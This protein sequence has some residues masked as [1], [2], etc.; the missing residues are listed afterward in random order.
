MSL[1]PD[2]TLARELH[3]GLNSFVCNVLQHAQGSNDVAE[4]LTEI[5][6]LAHHVLADTASRQN[7]SNFVYALPA[8][9]LCHILRFLFLEDLTNAS[10]TCRYFRQLALAEPSLWTHIYL[11]GRHGKF[12]RGIFGAEPYGPAHSWPFDDYL[13]VLLTRA[14]SAPVRLIVRDLTNT[15]IIPLAYAIRKHAFHLRAVVI[16][17]AHTQLMKAEDL[18]DFARRYAETSN[19][20]SQIVSYPDIVIA[21][22]LCEPAPLLTELNLSRTSSYGSHLPKQL[23]AACPVLS[24]IDLT[25]FDIP[26]IDRPIHS[27]TKL[28][29]V[30]AAGHDPRGMS[31]AD[32]FRKFP[33]LRDLEM[34][35]V[36]RQFPL[37]DMAETDSLQRLYIVPVDEN[38]QFK[39]VR[40]LAPTRIADITIRFPAFSIVRPFIESAGTIH[41]VELDDYGYYGQIDLTVHGRR[42]DES[43]T[44]RS[45]LVLNGKELDR[46][47]K[48]WH[49]AAFQSVRT[50][51]LSDG[52]H[53]PLAFIILSLMPALEE[54]TIVV[55]VAD[56]H[57]K[58][59]DNGV[60][61]MDADDGDI[62]KLPLLELP[63]LRL[64]RCKAGTP[65]LHMGE[66]RTHNARV[67]FL[68]D[69]ISTKFASHDFR[70]VLDGLTLLDGDD[71]GALD[72]LR[73]TVGE[74][75]IVLP[76]A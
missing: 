65:R 58:A 20:G 36:A 24:D 64:L 75:E 1:E 44:R 16:S 60:L 56:K 26:D 28:R 7:S 21:A 57:N 42:A 53:W 46:T 38:Y 76:A 4:T 2:L 25:G 62:Y 43:A 34:H 23:F 3:E 6:T 18:P 67:S 14:R 50:V 61:M 17:F 8:E 37:P 68:H 11:W 51:V 71:E 52:V 29:L 9:V 40:P 10:C 63:A 41:A 74:L 48:G 15:F 39:N 22:A 70:L 30:R 54:L 35:A 13:E 66:K 73:A 49:T 19:W 5:A 12:R 59:L 45:F 27:V 32:L 33:N 69:L 55:G 72:R 31:T 47:F